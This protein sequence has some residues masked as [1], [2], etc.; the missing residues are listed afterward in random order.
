MADNEVQFQLPPSVSTKADVSRLKRELDDFDVVVHQ[1]GLRG[2][3]KANE[4]SANLRQI[5]ELNKLNL[6]DNS[7][8]KTLEDFVASLANA[9][10]VHVSLAA[11]PSPH[12]MQELVSWFRANAHPHTLLQIGLQPTI[13]AGCVVRTTN[14]VFDLTLRT[15]IVNKREKLV[16]ALAGAQK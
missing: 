11:D 2:D 15:S 3:N 6:S 12:V 16:T 13:A 14:K 9:P 7:D 5:T 4:I 8:R 10:S 1:L